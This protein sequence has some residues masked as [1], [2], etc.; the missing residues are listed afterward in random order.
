MNKV[1][2]PFLVKCGVLK[3]VDIMVRTKVYINFVD[4]QACVIKN[5]GVFIT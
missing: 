5:N 2:V 1:L 4:E 3:D